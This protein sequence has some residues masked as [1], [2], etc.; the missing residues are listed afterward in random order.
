MVGGINFGLER[1]WSLI[2][3]L[4][5]KYPEATWEKIVDRKKGKGKYVIE[6]N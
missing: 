3:N 4:L 2:K 1:S 5:S 6:I